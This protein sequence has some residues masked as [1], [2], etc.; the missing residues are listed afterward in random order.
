MLGKDHNFILCGVKISTTHVEKYALDPLPKITLRVNTNTTQDSIF[1][2]THHNIKNY[3]H[4]PFQ[5][6]FKKT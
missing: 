6:L 3:T 5:S 4:N 2:P 1:F